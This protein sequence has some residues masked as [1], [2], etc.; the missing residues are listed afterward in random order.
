MYKWQIGG[1]SRERRSQFP[2]N[3]FSRPTILASTTNSSKNNINNNKTIQSTTNN[4][5]PDI[6]NNSSKNYLNHNPRKQA[7]QQS[8]QQSCTVKQQEI[9]SSTQFSKQS[10]QQPTS[11]RTILEAKFL[12]RVKLR[13]IDH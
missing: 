10:L 11:T 2:R 6:N 9:F 12:T 1:G 13:K 5:N 7:S 8:R 4:N 3:N